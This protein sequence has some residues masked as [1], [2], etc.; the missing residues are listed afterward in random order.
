MPTATATVD[1]ETMHQLFEGRHT[2]N[3][4]S[5][6]E[7]DLELI[8]QAYEDA[9]WGPTSMNS[10]PMRLTVLRPGPRR[11][12]VVEHFKGDNGKKTAAAPMTVV[13]AYDPDWHEHMPTLFPHVEGLREKFS[14]M[15]EFRRSMG[16][17]NAFLQAGY[18]IVSLRA[19]GL[20]VGPMAGLD[21]PGVDAE[22]HA[23]T[24]WKTLMVLNVGHGPS[25]HEGAQYPRGA[26]FS[27]DEAAQ[28]L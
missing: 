20:D 24:G 18:L 10:Q 25:E 3:L 17:D 1:R 6:G 28:V 11:D 16:R 19:H 8:Q 15:E 26:R 13:V 5:A 14:G 4:F 2:T 12:A 27:F 7:V 9:R 21:A 22:V 23:E